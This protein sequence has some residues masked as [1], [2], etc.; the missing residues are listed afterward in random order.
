MVGVYVA[1]NMLAHDIPPRGG[2]RVALPQPQSPAGI[3]EQGVTAHWGRAPLCNAFKLIVDVVMC[4]E[5]T[6]NTGEHTRHKS[7]DNGRKLRT[8]PGRLQAMGHFPQQ[9]HGFI[10]A[11]EF[12]V[13]FEQLVVARF[14]CLH[15][16][17]QP[18][19]HGVVALGKHVKLGAA[20]MVIHAHR[21][22]AIT[23]VGH[24]A[25]NL[26]YGPAHSVQHDIKQAVNQD[27]NN[28]T[29]TNDQLSVPAHMGFCRGLAGNKEFLL[30]LP[31]FVCFLD[32]NR[33]VHTALPQHN[34]GSGL[35]KATL[36]GKGNLLCQGINTLIG[37]DL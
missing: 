10:V 4:V 30:C 25:C 20:H 36:A 21:A 37:G 12:S 14:L 15:G 24:G 3:G 19:R 27:N 2:N 28:Q 22:V 26:A 5:C 11:F 29:A 33:H 31:D 1:C 32:N 7:A 8:G 13:G 34:P 18:G 16:G 35:F 6:G 23:K 17:I 9:F